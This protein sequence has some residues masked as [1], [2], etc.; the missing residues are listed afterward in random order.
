MHKTFDNLEE[1][2]SAI[3]LLLAPLDLLTK[4]K[5]EL[6]DKINQLLASQYTATMEKQ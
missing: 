2:S 3:W 1:N 6:P 5:S 4:E